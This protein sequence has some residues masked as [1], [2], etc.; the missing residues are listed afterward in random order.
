MNH[1]VRILMGIALLAQNIFNPLYANETPPDFTDVEDILLGQRHLLRNDDLVIA[2]DKGT[3]SS[4]SVFNQ[5]TLETNLLHISKQ[6]SQTIITPKCALARPGSLSLSVPINNVM[7]TRVGRVFELDR[8]VSVTL[9]PASQN[10]QFGC[11]GPLALYVNDHQNADNNTRTEVDNSSPMWTQMLL[12]DFDLDGYA[13]VFQNHGYG[14]AIHTAVDTSDPT[15][16][17]K[18][19]QFQGIPDSMVATTTPPVAGDF[20]GDGAVDIAWLASQAKDQAG[21][22]IYVISVCPRQGMK[23]NGVT[24]Q[25][26]FQTIPKVSTEFAAHSITTDAQLEWPNSLCSGCGNSVNKFWLASGNLDGRFTS[27]EGAQ[28][29]ELVFARVN[30]QQLEIH[31]YRLGNDLKPLGKAKKTIIKGMNV[32]KFL[33]TSGPINQFS[34]TDQL[35]LVTSSDTVLD[36]TT[37]AVVHF[38]ADLTAKWYSYEVSQKAF[39][40]TGRTRAFPFATGIT[41]G[42]FNPPQSGNSRDFNH[43]IAVLYNTVDTV[44]MDSKYK[45]M[46]H[47]YTVGDNADPVPALKSEHVVANQ[48]FNTPHNFQ[49]VAPLQVGDLRGRSL[50]LGEPDTFQV[51]SHIQPHVILGSPPQHVDYITPSR[52]DQP[53]VFNFSAI[54]KDF[55]STYAVQAS[56]E[57]Q[58]S[59][60][61]T[62]SSGWA[63][64]ESA[65]LKGKATIGP[66][67]VSGELRQ[68]LDVAEK[69]TV[70]ES[71]DTFQSKSFDASTTTGYGDQVWYS[72]RRMN[73]FIYPVLGKYQCPQNKKTCS[74]D[75]KQPMTVV[76]SGPDNIRSNI[77]ATGRNLE[78]YQPVHVPGQLFTYPWNEQQL[79][80][81]NP[82]L[83]SL[84]Q[85]ATGAFFTDDSTTTRKVNWKGSSGS[86]KSVGFNSSWALGGGVSVAVG[87]PEETYKKAGGVKGEVNFDMSYSNGLETLNTDTSKIGTSTGVAIKKPGSFPNPSYYQYLLEPFIFGSEDQLQRSE[88]TKPD[89]DILTRGPLQTAFAADPT[90]PGSGSWWSTSPYKQHID[91][92]FGFPARWE[93]SNSNSQGLMDKETACLGGECAIMD[94]PDA[95]NLWNSSFYWLRGFYI[96][97]NGQGPQ[98]TA[99]HTGDQLTLSVRVYNHSLK[100]MAKGDRLKVRF[101]GQQWD[102]TINQ[103]MAGVNS[104]LIGQDVFQSLPGFATGAEPNWRLAHTRFDTSQCG[105]SGCGDKYFVFWAMVWA[106]DSQQQIIKSELPGHGL[107]QALSSEALTALLGKTNPS[108]KAVFEV[109]KQG[110]MEF[111]QVN[112]NDYTSFSNNLG[113]FHQVFFIHNHETPMLKRTQDTVDIHRHSVVQQPVIIEQLTLSETHIKAGQEVNLTVNLKAGQHSNDAMQ[114]MVY[115]VTSSTSQSSLLDHEMIAHIK[116]NDVYQISLPIRPQ[117]CG[118][119]QIKAEL[120]LGEPNQNAQIVSAEFLD[121]EC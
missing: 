107:N 84:G 99:A 53:K 47:I 116:S 100:D 103:P 39:N 31:A 9:A 16:G 60:K 64:K 61:S 78:W 89:A 49:M 91:V 110:A 58:S 71:F 106:E 74:D 56:Q 43:Q 63:L 96:Q 97:S 65:S 23:I 22:S 35:A 37:L 95:N 70:S 86:Q 117:G 14:Y 17:L 13:D 75:E 66:V 50:L 21:L 87:T 115:Q 76:F 85:T 2:L 3:Q 109:S 15:Q 108:M 83:Q 26:P 8:D 77:S 98:R 46:L 105:S 73:V 121:I 18:R 57:N 45:T 10:G 104:F 62:T 112:D 42:R 4:G 32:S 119:Q 29:D 94:Q 69:N 6:S 1:S 48:Q 7:H 51:E 12:A 79:L 102:P 67:E 88:N 52:A 55:H 101:Y 41:I 93:I 24:C 33:L 38:E 72:S 11:E 27:T 113:Y 40:S 44:S 5:V 59:N 90:D 34:A 68:S 54:K 114:L 19:T 20:N 120:D 80:L 82:D 111:S 92:G 81:Q 28:T 118:R 30:Q 25:R 36:K